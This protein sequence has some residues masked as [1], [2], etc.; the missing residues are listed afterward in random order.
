MSSFTQRQTTPKKGSSYRGSVVRKFDSSDDDSSEGSDSDEEQQ[1]KRQKTYAAPHSSHGGPRHSSLDGRDKSLSQLR[2]GHGGRG[3]SHGGNSEAGSKR[4][5]NNVWGSIVEEQRQEQVEREIT[6]FGV[7]SVMSRDVESYSYSENLP[8]GAVSG[9]FPDGAPQHKRKLTK[10][11][12]EE[13]D[14]AWLATDS[15]GRSEEEEEAKGKTDGED[16]RERLKKRGSM[17]ADSFRRANVKSRLGVRPESPEPETP[18]KSIDIDPNG[19]VKVVAGQLAYSLQEPKRDLVLRIVKVLGVKKSI[20]IW[21]Q[22]EKIEHDGGMMIMNRSRRR[23]PGGV[24]IHMMKTDPDVSPQDIKEIFA[25]EKKIFE[26]ERKRRRKQHRHTR[27][28]AGSSMDTD[29]RNVKEAE[30]NDNDV[31]DDEKIVEDREAEEDMNDEWDTKLEG[32]IS[33]PNTSNGG[34]VFQSGENEENEPSNNA[35][36]G[37][38]TQSEFVDSRKESSSFLFGQHIAEED[39][40]KRNEDSEPED[41]EVIDDESDD[42][43]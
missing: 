23:S 12:G 36:A 7:S 28:I 14:D 9:M 13:E 37:Q 27:K 1:W 41:G 19:E 18:M 38:L 6:S 26:A 22:T 40:P 34:V 3:M 25:E 30:N 43:N 33:G 16:L 10:G 17:V 32:D 24:F 35:R 11:V 8:L 2:P 15:P 20:E 29:D 31:A 21:K 5:I 39:I 4:R 42:D